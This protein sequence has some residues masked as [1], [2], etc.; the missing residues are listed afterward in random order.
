MIWNID[1]LARFL[2]EAKRN[3]YASQKGG[4]ASSRKASKDLGYKKDG[5]YYLDSYFGE[6]D[7]SG[8]E[9]VYL[10][11]APMWS[12]NY[13]GR[14]RRDDV[15]PGFIETLREALLRVEEARPYRGCRSHTRGDYAY[16]C[17]SDGTILRFEG[18]ESI[19]YKAEE[20]YCLLFHGGQIR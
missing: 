15:A 17:R 16:H 11:G 18:R 13:Y 7:F 12:M 4:I 5:W 19:E 10:D 1:D 20:V 3:T 9:I 14:M 2:V 8:Q 6:K